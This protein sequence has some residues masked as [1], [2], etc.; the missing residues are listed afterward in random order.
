MGPLR[1]TATTITSV[2]NYWKFE[3]EMHV[4]G[5]TFGDGVQIGGQNNSM[6]IEKNQSPSL[7][8]D[9]SAVLADAVSAATTLRD[10]VSGRDRDQLEAALDQVAQATED[11]AEAIGKGLSG[12]LPIAGRLLGTV[13]AAS[14]AVSAVS[15][16]L[17][18][19][20]VG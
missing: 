11:D 18:A 17:H 9:A 2:S 10:Q 13:E 1:F 20:G 4:S 12:I 5:N 16:A 8:S 6:R 7:D 19:L 15:A 14:T 3:D